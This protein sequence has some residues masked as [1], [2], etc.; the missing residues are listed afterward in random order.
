VL[1][2]AGSTAKQD[3]VVHLCDGMILEDGTSITW[4]LCGNDAGKLI[5]GD[6]AAVTCSR[7]LAIEIAGRIL[8]GNVLAW[9]PPD[10]LS[11]SLPGS[12]Q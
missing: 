9:G 11:S 5:A 1:R 2:D 10:L 7:C 8:N 12:L 3:G 4:A 6:G